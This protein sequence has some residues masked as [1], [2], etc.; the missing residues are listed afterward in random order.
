MWTRKAPR[1]WVDW[2]AVNP[3]P[4]GSEPV[5][6]PSNDNVEEMLE[7]VATGAGVCL[8]TESMAAYYSHPD[9]VWRP[10]KDVE[11]LVIAVA[12]PRRHAHPLAPGF[13]RT[14][15]EVAA[16]DPVTKGVRP[17]RQC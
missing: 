3:R 14:V 2:W 11:P 6:G 8:A 12:C 10:V 1:A 9:L 16:G 5:W 13:L 7:H 15:R 4:D 17:R